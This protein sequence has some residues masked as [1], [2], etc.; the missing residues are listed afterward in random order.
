MKVAQIACL[1]FAVFNIKISNIN[2]TAMIMFFPVIFLFGLFP[3]VNTFLLFVLEQIDIHV[4]GGNR[5]KNL[6]FHCIIVM[7]LSGYSSISKN[8][9]AGICMVKLEKCFKFSSITP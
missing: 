5:E 1:K 4:F 8:N 7:T 9:Y 6:T 2:F 3:Q